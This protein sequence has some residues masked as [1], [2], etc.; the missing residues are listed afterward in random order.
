MNTIDDMQIE[1][2]FFFHCNVFEYILYFVKFLLE[3]FYDTLEFD[4]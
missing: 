2:D 1:M 3:I 4:V